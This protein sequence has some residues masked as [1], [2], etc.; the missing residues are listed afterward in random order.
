MRND[1]RRAKRGSRIARRI[2]KRSKGHT[3]T[4]PRL[5]RRRRQA[6]CAPPT[7]GSR[8]PF[9]SFASFRVVRDPDFASFASFRVVRDPDFTSFAS[10][11]V[12][13]DPD[14]ASFAS[15]RV[16][17]DPKTPRSIRLAVASGQSLQQ[18]RRAADGDS[19]APDADYSAAPTR[20]ARRRGSIARCRVASGAE[21]KRAVSGPRFRRLAEQDKCAS[22]AIARSVPPTPEE[23]AVFARSSPVTGGGWACRRIVGDSSRR[24]R[25]QRI[26]SA[27]SAA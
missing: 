2:A 7:R 9:T 8:R 12:V 26:A 18:P 13:R 11:R 24:G 22:G 19:R 6:F 3:W 27:I 25:G 1:A 20:S 15:F 23:C 4:G 14:F 21:P 16:V 10:F 17:R 5:A